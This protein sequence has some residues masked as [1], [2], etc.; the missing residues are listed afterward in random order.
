MATITSNLK[1]TKPSGN[2]NVS[3]T[4]LN[5]NF[6]KIDS[7]IGSLQTDY[8][9]SQGTQGIWTYRRWASGIAECWI[10]AYKPP[11]INFNAGWGQVL[12]S[13]S[14]ASPGNY[15]FTFKSLPIVIPTWASASQYSCPIWSKPYGGSLTKC[16][17]F[18][19]I[20]QSKGSQANAVIGVY[21][22]GTWK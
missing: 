10:E 21:V 13:A 8:V 2:E 3:V 11:T 5:E 9:V 12:W 4:V 20:D 17:D 22:K 14:I 16:P 19:A 1:L 18:Q 6:D 7:E 15:P